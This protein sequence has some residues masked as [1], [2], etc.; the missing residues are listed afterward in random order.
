MLGHISIGVTDLEAARR[1]YDATMPAFGWTR[2]WTD[3]GGLG[4]GPEE[5]KDKINI[6]LHAQTAPPGPGFHLA[7]DAP[8]RGAVDAFYAAAMA[9]GGSDAGPPGLRSHYGP[10]YY[11][12]FVFDPEGWKLE[13]VHQ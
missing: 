9:N 13:A 4:Y 1:F 6:F 5:G 2:V 8:D 12:A 3:P 10:D 11:A 7:L